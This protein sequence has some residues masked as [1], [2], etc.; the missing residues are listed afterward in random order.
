M[1]AASLSDLGSGGGALIP[2]DPALVRVRAAELR[3]RSDRADE[4]GAGLREIELGAWTGRAAQ[5]FEDKF[6]GEPARWF[7]ASDSLALAAEALEAFAWT[8]EWARGQAG[9]AVQ[10]WDQGQA[11]SRQAADRYRA[12]QAAG[13]VAVPFTDPGQGYRDAAQATLDNARSQLRSA[14]ASAADT[15]R[16]Q[17]GYAPQKSSWLDAAGNF[18]QEAGA[19]AV[20]GLASFAN[21]MTNHPGDVAQLVGGT[22]LMDAGVAGELGG[23]LLDATGVGAPP[24]IALNAASAA[25]IATGAGIAAHGATSLAAHAATDDYVTPMRSNRSD[26][27][28]NERHGDGGRTNAKNQAQI[29]RLE[30]DLRKLN[31]N[32]GSRREKRALEEKIKRLRQA[33]ARAARGEEHSRGAKR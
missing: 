24:G 13:P 7:N 25:V 33:G 2:G 15:L 4:A 10:Q 20:N 19:G 8:L 5:E 21:A 14:A 18:L 11:L 3:T 23:L 29:D 22:F 1:G 9:V 26:S 6:A 12:A 28:N 17:A 16:E 31:Q 30:A 32:Q 27:S